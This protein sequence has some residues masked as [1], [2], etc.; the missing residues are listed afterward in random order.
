VP[1]CAG[2]FR[3][4]RWFAFFGYRDCGGGTPAVARRAAIRVSSRPESA[5]QYRS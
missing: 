4:G 2:A 1:S 5:G 3:H